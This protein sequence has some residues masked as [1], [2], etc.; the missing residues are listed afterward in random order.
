MCIRRSLLA[1]GEPSRRPVPVARPVHVGPTVPVGRGAVVSSEVNRSESV[2]WPRL[3]RS[4]VFLVRS[5]QG[6]RGDQNC[7]ENK[8]VVVIPA[9]VARHA[10]VGRHVL[11]LR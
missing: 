11:A 7:L 10:S 6:Y 3:L 1:A 9:F 5:Q 2:R 8:L 4:L